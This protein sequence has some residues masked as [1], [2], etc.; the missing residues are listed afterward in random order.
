MNPMGTRDIFLRQYW[1]LIGGILTLLVIFALDMLVLPFGMAAGELYVVAI[2]VGLFTQDRRFIVCMGILSSALTAA[3]FF[4]AAPEGIFW[5]V[6]FNRAVSIMAIWITVGLCLWLCRAGETLKAAHDQLEGKV[7]GRTA[8]L[9]ASNEAL[10]REKSLVQLLKDIAIASNESKPLKQIMEY[11]L[12]R[13]CG[14]MNWPV[15]HVYFAARGSGLLVPT[16]YWHLDEPERFEAFRKATEA[17]SFRAGEGLPGQVLAKGEA[18]WIQDVTRELIFPRASLAVELGV[19]SAFGFPIWAG[20]DMAGVMEFFSSEISEPDSELLDIVSQL[21][22]LLGRVKEKKRA[23]EDQAG[24]IQS[25]NSQVSKLTCLYNVAKLVGGR[26]TMGEVMKEVGPYVVTSFRYPDAVRIRADFGGATYVSGAFEETPWKISARIVVDG[27]KCGLLEAYSLEERPRGGDGPFT[28]EER[29]LIDGLA[30]YLSLAAANKIALEQ[31][32]KSREELRNL[33]RRQEL[34]REEERSRIAR[35]VH[36][37][38]AQALLAWKLDLAWLERRI[39]RDG[40]GMV[41]E[42]IKAMYAHLEDTLREVHRISAELR[43]QILDIMGLC[44]ALKWQTREFQNRTG[45]PCEL[46]L[47]PDPVVLPPNLSTTLF[48]IYQETLVNVSRHAQATRVFSSFERLEDGRFVLEVR[49][50]G[51]GIK[52]EQIAD[53]NSFGI[54]GMRERVMPWGGQ[55]DIQGFHGKGTLVS[56]TIPSINSGE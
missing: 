39:S 45:I 15:G 18:Y 8:A 42:K 27:R 49:D 33:Y 17:I 30:N 54:I 36:D 12:K 14:H 35:E 11:S 29:N 51:I 7:R 41:S 24:L 53:S 16:A 48:R 40:P 43:P 19:R 21:G 25:L 20:K 4:L 3:K 50:N 34:T 22:T 2:L 5:T 13:I 1:L 28:E 10:R 47:S 6:L 38:L 9:H 55:I 52:S 37:E 23:E 31:I 44:E 26:K 56:V 46:E 32:E